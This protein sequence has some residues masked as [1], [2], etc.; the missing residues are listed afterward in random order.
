LVP[1][2]GSRA[3]D[4]S[5]VFRCVD[6]AVVD[7]EIGVTITEMR[8]WLGRSNECD[9]VQSLNFPAMHIYFGTRKVCVIGLCIS[10]GQLVRTGEPVPFSAPTPPPTSNPDSLW[11]TVDAICATENADLSSHAYFALASVS[12]F[13]FP[14]RV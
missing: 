12:N 6:F 8:E 1:P 5:R 13:T 3:F 11:E 2:P 14:A 9:W 4:T 7:S 10:A